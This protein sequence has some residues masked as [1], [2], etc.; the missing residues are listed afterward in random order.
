[1]NP[2]LAQKKKA[3]ENGI[4]LEEQLKASQQAPAK[5]TSP[6]NSYSSR[7]NAPAGS[8]GSGNKSYASKTPQKSKAPQGTPTAPY[9]FIKLNDVVVSAQFSEKLNAGEEQQAYKEFLTSEEVKYSGYFEIKVEN[10]TPFFINN[11]K[12]KFFS[13]GV[14]YLIP[15]SSLRGAIKNYFK[16]LTNGTMRTGDDGDVTDKYLY[17]RTFA[18]P[19]KDLSAAYKREMTAKDP[20][21]NIDLPSSKPGFLVREGKKYYICPATF[22]RIKDEYKAQHKLSAVEW[23]NTAVNVF[24]GPM[25]NKKHYYQFTGAQWSKKLEIPEKILLSYF[26][27]KN[28]NKTNKQLRLFDE[29]GNINKAIWK[30]GVGSAKLLQGASAYDYVVPCFYVADNDIVRHFGSGP[31]YRI[32]Y[33]K[34]IG[35]HIPAKLNSTVVDFT[36]AMFG[37]KE[38]WGSRVYFENLYLKDGQ[39][40]SFEDKDRAIPLLGANPTSFQNYLETDNT[41]KAAYWNAASNI[42][43]YKLYWH[44]KCDWRKDKNDKNQNVNVSKEFA[45][46]KQGHTFVGRLRFENLSAVE[47]GALANVLSLGDDGSSAYKLGMGKPIGM[48]SVHIKAKLYL[49]NDA[50]YTTL[51]SEAGFDSGVELGDKQKYIGIFKQYM[52]EMLTPASLRLYNERIEELHYIMDDSHLQ[53]SSW[54][55]KT[56]YM[57]INNGKD[58]DLANHRIPLPSIKDVVNKR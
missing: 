38:N 24:T 48:G 28:G 57:N 32:P 39:K 42:R 58:K 11:G 3:K 50:Y 20:E 53:D 15:G 54:A 55:A 12:D 6:A 10:I 56:A 43:G 7:G 16:I 1:M 17:Y 25:R 36:A 14:N 33:K 2:Y 13:D 37:N 30:A 52:N 9:N 45:P 46:L 31:L 18:S 4:S 26:T 40:A 21:K 27:D 22:K 34:S 44:K 8:R 47:L 23:T 41:G 19:F 35:E 29:F 5:K 51:F 49:Q